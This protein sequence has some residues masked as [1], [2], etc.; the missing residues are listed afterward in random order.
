MDG[1]NLSLLGYYLSHA[2]DAIFQRCSFND[3]L[4]FEVLLLIGRKPTELYTP[5]FI[6]KKLGRTH[7]MVL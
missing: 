5:E 2:E 6:K 1:Y 7:F 3:G 4:N